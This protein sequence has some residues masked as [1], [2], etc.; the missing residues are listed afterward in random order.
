MYSMALLWFIIAAT[1]LEV[2]DAF[3]YQ[4]TH[5]LICRTF[6]NHNPG[7]C[8]HVYLD[9]SKSLINSNDGASTEILGPALAEKPRQHLSISA[10]AKFDISLAVILAGYSF[11]AYN[12]PVQCNRCCC[13]MS[14]LNKFV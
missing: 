11:E 14:C 10:P 12:E 13:S 9:A 7:Y 5:R 6:K 3:L 8:N 1:A 2:Y 4:G